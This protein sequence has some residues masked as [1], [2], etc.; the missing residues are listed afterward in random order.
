[1]TYIRIY[2][3]P[4][5]E[6]SLQ[7][8]HPWIFSGAIKRI[9]GEPNEG[10]LVE[11]VDF[12]G[13][14][15]AYGHYQPGSITVRVV[16]FQ[17]CVIDKEFWKAKLTNALQLRKALGLYPCQATNIF[18]LV[19]GEGDGLPGLI[20]DIYGSTAVM[21]VHS[22][23][24]GI[25]KNLLAELIIEVM[26]GAVSSVYEKS[27]GTLSPKSPVQ[28]VDGYIIGESKKDTLVENGNQF[29]VSWVDGQKTGFFIDQ[30]DNRELVAK[31]SK[32]A[33]ILNAFCYTG[34]FSVYAARSGAKRV[35]SVDSSQKAIEL[36]SRNMAINF[37]DVNP[38]ESVC[39][40]VFDFLKDNDDK[41]DMII[42]DP[43]AFAKHRG[44][45]NNALQA[46]KRLNAAAFT[47][48][49]QGGIL[50]TFSCSQV[51]SRDQFRNAVFSGSI[52]ANRN[53]RIMHQLTQP[54]DHP[55]NIYH[56]EGEYLKGLVLY[57]D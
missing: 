51:V 30:R 14:F 28:A 39:A 57:V 6:Q 19:H 3:K 48:L 4:G 45:L 9:D 37:G 40:D 34:G 10:E 44:A 15:L 53:V 5:K 33:S 31:Y 17:K 55:I 1:M 38:Y 26:A 23:G 43:P 54:A 12:K 13:Q 20:I 18:R 50:F 49:K 16:S 22:S 11:V 24:M 41:F 35:V 25:I 46:Y 21:Q 52:I 2:L 8:F 29:L 47:K 42:L 36:T 56:P 7:R 27:S 32:D